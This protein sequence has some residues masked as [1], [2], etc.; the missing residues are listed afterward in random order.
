MMGLSSNTRHNPGSSNSSAISKTIAQAK[1]RK[2]RANRGVS[3]PTQFD[4]NNVSVNGQD[5]LHNTTQHAR[6]QSINSNV[7]MNMTGM[8]FAPAESPSAAGN[9]TAISGGRKPTADSTAYPLYKAHGK[10]NA[11]GKFSNGGGS[12]GGNDVGSFDQGS[13]Q[14]NSIILMEKGHHANASNFSTGPHT[15]ASRFY[16]PNR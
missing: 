12:I 11:R 3:N 9:H 10:V 13:F 6:Q 1:L 8:G 15:T 4:H 16:N 14:N 5:Y 7:M 2:Q